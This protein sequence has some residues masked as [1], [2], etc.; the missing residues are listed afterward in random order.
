QTSFKRTLFTYTT[1][2]RS[3]PDKSQRVGKY[4]SDPDEGQQHTQRPDYQF[5]PV[6]HSIVVYLFLNPVFHLER[7]VMPQHIRQ[8]GFNNTQLDR[9]STR[10]NYSHVSISY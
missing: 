3:L 7:N 9:K 2:F 6:Q 8:L 4:V 1:I 10:L 5:V